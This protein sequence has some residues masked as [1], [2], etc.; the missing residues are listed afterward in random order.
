MHDRHG[1]PIVIAAPLAALLTT[2]A[3]PVRAADAELQ[4]TTEQVEPGIEHV[5][6]LE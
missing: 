1:A 4:L 3:S 6:V 2:T 5:L